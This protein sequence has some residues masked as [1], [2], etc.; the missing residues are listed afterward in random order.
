MPDKAKRSERTWGPS[1]VDTINEPLRITGS[2]LIGQMDAFA[3]D[4]TFPIETYPFARYAGPRDDRN[5]ELCRRLHNQIFDRRD[6]SFAEFTPPV[7]INCR[8]YWTFIGKADGRRPNFVRP[9]QAIIDRDGHFVRDPEKYSPLRVRA[10]ANGRDFI[11]RR[12]K[13]ESG[14]VVS[15]IT[16]RQR[17]MD[18]PVTGVENLLP[19]KEEVESGTEP[20]SVD[21]V[22]RFLRELP[23]EVRQAPGLTE[24]AFAGDEYA[25]HVAQVPPADQAATL[26]ALGYYRADTGQVVLNDARLHNLPNAEMHLL[27]TIAHESG[28]AWAAEANSPD[29]VSP[30]ALTGELLTLFGVAPTA[31]MQ[32]RTALFMAISEDNQ[33]RGHVTDYA[34]TDLGE[35]EAENVRLFLRWQVENDSAARSRIKPRKRTVA[36]LKSLLGL[37]LR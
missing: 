25:A 36:V 20:W 5:S 18:A 26:R 1:A 33:E 7:H 13:D 16:W 3:A 8:H 37:N 17:G 34:M 29:S 15:K 35:D 6:P 32:A 30:P 21:K 28:H 19:T 31:T 24:M 22:R 23:R 2:I 14:E 12:V 4:T 11:F 27:D 10:R 9:E